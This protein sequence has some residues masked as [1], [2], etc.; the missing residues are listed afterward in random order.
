MARDPGFETSFKDCQT[1][2]DTS[3]L[4][5][6]KKTLE[7]VSNPDLEGEKFFVER[8][9]KNQNKTTIKVP[10]QNG[11]CL[12]QTVIEPNHHSIR[13]ELSKERLLFYV[14]FDGGEASLDKE[15]FEKLFDCS[16]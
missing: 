10:P 13:K 11:Y 2:L 16:L 1:E 7:L 8:D 5:G 14:E 6:I 4:S 9:A 3:L 12:A 15:N